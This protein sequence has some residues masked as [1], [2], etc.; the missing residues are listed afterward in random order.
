M[1]NLYNSISKT[2]SIQARAKSIQQ[3]YNPAE[4]VGSATTELVGFATLALFNQQDK[5]NE[6]TCKISSKYSP[7]IL[8]T[9]SHQNQ[10]F[11][12]SKRG[13]KHE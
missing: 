7:G 13:C 6:L 11:L 5:P 8:N 12:A 3:S 4:L 10:P 9:T 1:L 2:T